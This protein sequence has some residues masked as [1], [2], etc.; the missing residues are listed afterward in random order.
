[1]ATSTSITMLDYKSQIT[2]NCEF[3][4]AKYDVVTVITVKNAM[5]DY[6]AYAVRSTE[7]V[8]DVLL[9]SGCHSTAM[10]A[11]ESLYNKS[12]EATHQYITTNGFAYPPDLKKA[13]LDGGDD[14]DGKSETH[15]DADTASIV[16]GRSGRSAS[17]TVALSYWSGSEDE[18]T[19]TPAGSSPAD[20]HAG[21]R[22]T[23]CSS[24][25]KSNNISKRRSK[26]PPQP[27]VAGVNGKQAAARDSYLRFPV[28]L[29]EDDEDDNEEHHHHHHQA[30]RRL[31][32]R[33]RIESP[34]PGPSAAATNNS[35]SS[36]SYRPPPPPP[37]WSGPPV[38][39]PPPPMR[40]VP[41]SAT[42]PQ[43]QQRMH[44][45][46]QLNLVPGRFPG[47]FTGAATT[48]A[49]A[50][51]GAPPAP[52]VSTASAPALAP[53]SP[54][55]KSGVYFEEE[56]SDALGPISSSSNNGSA[57]QSRPQPQPQPRQ[58]QQQQ[59]QFPLPYPIPPVPS[60]L[61]DVRLTIHWLNHG[62]QRILESSRPSIRA[63]QELALSYVRTHAT[64]FPPSQQSQQSQS[65]DPA[66]PKFKTPAGWALRACVRRAHF[67][68]GDACDMSA[69]RGDDLTKL[70]NVLSVGGIPRFE[71]E[72]EGVWGSH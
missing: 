27:A 66:E 26:P 28:E 46:Q 55:N 13:R 65:S 4:A 29:F 38:S 2:D 67:G 17:S 33:F 54:G 40:G 47:V 52:P 20:P 9:S 18:A 5:G 59:Q 48:P 71:V 24:N 61:Y 1:M 42:I 62:E 68:P 64:S 58:Q 34:G 30:H 57:T 12:C 60:R 8:R 19:M 70:F 25:E 50:S 7:D 37:G 43:I 44:A 69:Y 23:G 63:L 21:C 53:I 41:I 6:I 36:T 51:A 35:S 11:L 49:A 14:E 22:E 56:S 39:Q 45:Y 10:D 31:P 72:V 32:P 16:S 3:F 15:D